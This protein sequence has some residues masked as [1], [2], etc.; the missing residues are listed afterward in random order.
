MPSL[1][2]CLLLGREK[3]SEQSFPRKSGKVSN[4]LLFQSS[5]EADTLAAATVGLKVL[6]TWEVVSQSP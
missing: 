4:P 5:G 6:R 3:D 2:E 1:W